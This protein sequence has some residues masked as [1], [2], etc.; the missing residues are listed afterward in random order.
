MS[1]GALKRGTGGTAAGPGTGRA[2]NRFLEPVLGAV[3][4]GANGELHALP[5]DIGSHAVLIAGALACL[6]PLISLVR[7]LRSYAVNVPYSDQ[8]ELVPLIEEMLS[9]R[10]ELHDLYAQ[11]GEHRMVVPRLV[12]LAA[13]RITRWDIRAEL[14]IDLVL[15]IGIFCLL[16]MLM[17]RSLRGLGSWMVVPGAALSLMLFSPVQWEDWFWGWQISWYL[18]LLAF[19]VAGAALTLWPDDRP[20]WPALLMAVF[21]AVAGQYSLMS[22]TLIWVVCLPLLLIRSQF[23]RYWWVWVGA[24]GASTVGYLYG[25]SSPP[26]ME[27]FKVSVAEI[28]GSPMLALRYV[29]YYLGRPILDDEPSYVAGAFFAIVFTAA[30]GY[31]LIRRRD[32][33]PAAAVWLAIGSHALLSAIFTMKNRMGLGLEYAGSSRYTTIGIL[34]MVST[35]VL[36]SLALVPDRG[37]SRGRIGALTIVWVTLG[38]LFLAD[39]S[40]EVDSLRRWH[41]HREAIKACLVNAVA[42]SDPCLPIAYPHPDVVFER[43]QYLKSI[44]W[45]GFGN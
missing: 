43:V 27:D 3:R 7:L 12:M 18:P 17:V 20:A 4:R 1:A 26:Y 25:Y 22:G 15:A 33:L 21:A 31:L 16:A 29:L 6:A 23:R 2:S 8:W 32:R 30:A 14:F 24:A 28:A 11:H 10:L 19:L 5:P 13:A 42:P 41:A 40:S 35:A 34:F 44:G 37:A 9:G 38:V 45:A 36:V 39:Y